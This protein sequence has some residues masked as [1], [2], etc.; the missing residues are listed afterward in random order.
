M[1]SIGVP[2]QSHIAS[3]AP[4]SIPKESGVKTPTV[5]VVDDSNVT[6][7]Y[8]A[9]LV[10]R[11]GR[12]RS[13]MASGGI[14]AL[15]MIEQDPPD[16]VVTDVQMP[17]MSGLELV[18]EIRKRYAGLPVILMTANGSEEIAI[19]ALRAGAANY[20][21]KQDISRDLLE[22]I[23]AVL[24]LST[25]LHQQPKKRQTDSSIRTT[26]Q[27]GND[28]QL[29][30]PMVAM[31]QAGLD[32]MGICDENGRTRV[33]VALQEALANALF[34]GNLEVSSDLRQEDERLFYVQA[35]A[36][37]LKEPY[38][39]RQIEVTADINR[40][41]ATYT[42]RD[43]GTGYK[44]PTGESALEPVDLMRIGGRGLILIRTFMDEVR[45]NELGN[46]I[47]LV[48]RKT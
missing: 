44:V 41:S 11:R 19:Q 9:A 20:V 12:F 35:D 34:H 24:S 45:H 22:T 32:V 1:S 33:G 21:P 2:A 8:V 46:E 5:L 39:S 3:Q 15:R 26:F 23:E 18:G 43:E 4:Q 6:R 36:N 47:T 14:E 27:I 25:I 31:L 17:D 10:G 28:S 16:V 13:L 29:I 30:A 40:D 37:R 48:K 38:R 42:I 7:L